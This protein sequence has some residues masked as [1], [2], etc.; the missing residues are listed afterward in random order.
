MSRVGKKPIKIP[1]GVE[2]RKED[3]KTI[4]KGPKGELSWE[5]RPEIEIEIKEGEVIVSPKK[6]TK[7][8]D[9]F[10][11]LTR[12]LIANMIQGVT[13]GF[14]KQLEI[15]GVG[16]KAN[17]EGE[18]LI[19]HVGFSHLVKIKKP[20]EIELSVKKNIISV[21]GISKQLVGETAARIR[22]V[23]PPEPYKGKGIRYLDEI[24]RRKESKKAATA[25]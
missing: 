18:D 6:E 7:Q 13:E 19:L 14:E 24:V 5:V 8:T 15:N 4:V 20:E 9:A 17:M 11:G 2:V 3:R 22:K 1:E 21:S 12:T 10:W 25:A 16:Y 23:R